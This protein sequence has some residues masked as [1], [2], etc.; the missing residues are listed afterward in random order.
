MPAPELPTLVTADDYCG[1]LKIATPA[2]DTADRTALDAAL[3]D[4][5]GALRSVIGQPLTPATTT[6]AVDWNAGGFF[7]IPLSPVT[8]VSAVSNT[9][10]TVDP[11]LYD[12]RGQRIYVDPSVL[13][14][15]DPRC[16]AV[17]QLTV[18]VVHG[19]DPI[20]R[21]VQ[22]WVCVLAAAQLC[23]VGRGHL[24]SNGGLTSIA[25]DDGKATYVDAVDLI[26]PRVKERLRAD[27]GGEP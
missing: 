11:S 20:P 15:T 23:A 3:L 1:R 25:V 13:G 16:L 27:F 6:L 2:V 24:G 14:G 9:A 10:G 19:W 5:S 26:P 8:A 7:L 17:P 21:D 18:T 22:R 4:A 12:V